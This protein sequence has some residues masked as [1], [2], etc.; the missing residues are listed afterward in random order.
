MK[1]HFTIPGM[2]SG[3]FYF[4]FF[5]FLL[6][7]FLN[8][9]GCSGG[10]EQNQTQNQQSFSGDKS[11]SFKDNGSDWRVDFDDEDISAVYKDGTRVPD[12]EIENYKDMIYD[13]IDELKTD[14]ERLAGKFHHYHFDADKFRNKMRKF[15]MDF[16]NDKFLHFKIDIDEDALEKNMK[17]LEDNLKVL[18]D[19]KIEIYFDSE[20]FKENMKELE[21]NLKNLPEPPIPPDIDIDVHINMD[22]FKENMKKFEKEF[23]SHKFEFDSSCID[24]S[25]L[26]ESLRELK[27]NMKGLHIDMS[28]LKVEMKKLNSFISDL[29]S[30]LAKDGYLESKNDELNLK[31]NKDETEVN[32]KE[33]KPEDHKKYLEM[34]RKHFDKDLEGTFRINR[35]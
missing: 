19:K 16:D 34:Y 20:K 12:S 9:T 24:M 14:Q 10:L 21:E 6:I 31:M 33:V 23:K 26:K 15:K 27:E 18:K 4:L 22:E 2:K 28:D 35:D 1:K 3:A 13:Q 25:G 30:E 29:K 7:A 17:E 8:L 11:F 5:P 32:G